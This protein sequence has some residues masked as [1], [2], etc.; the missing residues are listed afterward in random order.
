MRGTLTKK[1]VATAAIRGLCVLLTLLCV[2]LTAL[3]AVG[4]VTAR[5]GSEGL[6]ERFAATLAEQGSTFAGVFF[7][8]SELSAAT[9]YDM[10]SEAYTE[11]AF[12]GEYTPKT[13]RIE[14]RF[15]SGYICTGLDP[16][17]FSLSD[18]ISNEGEIAVGLPESNALQIIGDSLTY[19]DEKDGYLVTAMGEDGIL[20]IGKKT[21]YEASVSGYTWGFEAT[22]VLMQGGRVADDLGGGYG[23]RFAIGQA[24]DGSIILIYAEGNGFFYPSGVTYDELASLMYSL[25]AVNAAAGSASGGMKVDGE[26]I[27]RGARY[28]LIFRGK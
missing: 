21:P 11:I 15:W 20:H 12:S 3:W 6:A 5:G 13:E 1:R 8:S 17:L 24:S 22:R 27:G 10:P 26:E 28:T 25:G 16:E 4:L 18:G 7:Y 2:C 14:G 23:D 9:A 19:Y